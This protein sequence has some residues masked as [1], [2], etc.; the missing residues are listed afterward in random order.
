MAKYSEEKLT[1]ALDYLKAELGKQSNA[2]RSFN[3]HRHIGQAQCCKNEGQ[4]L[5]EFSKT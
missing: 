2:W 5:M 4:I 1:W 3:K